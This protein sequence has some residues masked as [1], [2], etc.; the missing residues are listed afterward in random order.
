MQ[1]DFDIFKRLCKLL[2]EIKTNN[3]RINKKINQILNKYSD[4][5]IQDRIIRLQNKMLE[6]IPD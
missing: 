6:Q 1:T 2:G 5:N 3:N 4:K